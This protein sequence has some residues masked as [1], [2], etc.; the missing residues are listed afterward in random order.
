VYL[1]APGEHLGGREPG[2]TAADDGDAAQ[3]RM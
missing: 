3:H 1:R 2:R